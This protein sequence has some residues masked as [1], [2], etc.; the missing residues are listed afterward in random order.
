MTHS[1]QD[2]LAIGRNVIRVEAEGLLALEGSLG[3]SFLDAIDII[4]A[5]DQHLI[6][7]GIGKSGHIGRKIAASFASMGTPAFFVHPSEAAHGDLGMIT[8]GTIVLGLSNSGES[9]EVNGV[10]EYAKSLGN[11][12]L[13]ITA[14][15]QS[16]LAKCADIAL[17]LP[18]VPEACPNRL[19]PTTSTT[20]TLALGDALGVAVMEAR[21]FTA[22]DFGRRHP[23]GKLGFGLKRVTE[24]LAGQNPSVP[25]IQPDARM[26]DVIL[27]ITGGGKGCVGVVQDTQLIGIVTDGDLRRAMGPDIMSQTASMIMTKDPFTLAPEMRIKDAITSFTERK[28]GNAFVLDGQNIIGLIDLKTLLATGYV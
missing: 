28:I 23:A 4:L 17:L 16:T 11:Q 20:L 27:A 15:P 2:H 5:C 8:A 22:E 14:G 25:L 19:A 9:A 7:V 6:I 24:Y 12:T 1:H 26:A 13:A 10:I 18:N 21:G 3:Q